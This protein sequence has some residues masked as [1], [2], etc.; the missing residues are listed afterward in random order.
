MESIL[1]PGLP[2]ISDKIF[3]SS[4]R[5]PTGKG[6]DAYGMTPLYIAAKNG[7]TKIVELYLEHIQYIDNINYKYNGHTTIEAAAI[8]GHFEIVNHLLPF[9]T[10]L[11]YQSIAKMPLDQHT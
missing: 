3:K 9:T 2:H 8:N 6:P 7:S 1:N 5:S 10:D 11:E 4:A